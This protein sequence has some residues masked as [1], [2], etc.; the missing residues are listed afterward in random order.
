MSIYTSVTKNAL[1]ST[2]SS[3]L[4]ASGTSGHRLELL[5][6]D[7]TMLCRFFLP[8]PPFTVAPENHLV[9]T[10]QSDGIVSATGT[11]ATAQYLDTS[12][13]VKFTIPAVES[14]A[15]VQNSLALSATQLIAGAAISLNEF[16][17]G[18]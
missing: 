7:Q 6:A 16:T 3:N 13:N 11:V 18:E 4:T 8:D 10:V 2:L 1:I 17:I 14:V 5:D 15:A 9:F 12:G